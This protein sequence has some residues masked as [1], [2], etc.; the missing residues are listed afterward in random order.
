MQRGEIWE[1]DLPP[2]PGGSGREQTGFRP[3]VIIHNLPD[4][5]NPMVM[6][7]PFT[8]NMAA[9]RFPHSLEVNPTKENGLSSPSVLM[10]FQLRAVDKRRLKRRLGSVETV[11]MSR[12]EDMLRELL[13]L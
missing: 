10:V 8:S 13:G 6:I 12:I 5:N 1:V 9:L 11:L 3:V 7:I 4:P 2:P